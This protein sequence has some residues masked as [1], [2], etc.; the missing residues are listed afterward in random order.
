MVSNLSGYQQKPL[1][2]TREPQPREVEKQQPDT[3]EVE[4]RRAE[5]RAV[6]NKQAEKSKA[7]AEQR[8]VESSKPRQVMQEL[9]SRIDLRA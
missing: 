5:A 3:R 2:Y 1:E 6:D 4:Q 7:A 9:G 8:S